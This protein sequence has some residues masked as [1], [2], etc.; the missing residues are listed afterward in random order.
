[1]AGI[2][3]PDKYFAHLHL[4]TEFSFLDGAGRIPDIVARAKEMGH[5]AVAITDHGTM[6]GCAE[7]YRECRKN[8][9]NPIIGCEFYVTPYGHSRTERKRYAVKELNG[10]PE[11]IRNYYHLNLWAKD[12]EGYRNLCRLQKMAN[13]EGFYMKPRIDFD[14]LRECHEGLI[15]GSACVLGEVADALSIGNKER[16]LER[17]RELQSIFDDDLY[18]EIMYHGVDIEAH[19]FPG[20]REVGKELSIP[21]IATN[22]AHYV[23]KED[24]GLQKALM[25][26]G[27]K[28]SLMDPGVNL[29]YDDIMG[30]G[31]SAPFAGYSD[32]SYRTALRN[33][34]M[35]LDDEEQI[36]SD[37]I[38]EMPAEL[39]MKDFDE[40]VH[41][42]GGGEEAIRECNNTRLVTEKCHLEMPW[43]KDIGY[44]VPKYDISTDWRYDE[45]SKDS[46][47]T[48]PAWIEEAVDK[49]F[50]EPD[51]K[52]NYSRP[53]DD[54]EKEDLRFLSWIACRALDKKVK[55]KAERGGK[56]LD[57][58]AWVKVDDDIAEYADKLIPDIH[59]IGNT[60]DEQFFAAHSFDEAMG[61]YRDRLAYEL[62]VVCRMHFLSYFEIVGDYVAWSRE[63]TF[64]GA[65]RGC[66]VPGT[67]VLTSNGI[68]PIEDV[69]ASDMVYDN[70]GTA[71]PLKTKFKY[72]VSEDMARVS[73]S[74]TDPIECTADHKVEV[75][76]ATV[77]EALVGKEAL[78]AAD[79]GAR[80]RS[81][82]EA[83]RREHTALRV[84]G[85]Y[86]PC[87]VLMGNG[88][89]IASDDGTAGTIGDSA[90]HMGISGSQ[91]VPN[92][93]D[94]GDTVAI[95]R[96]KIEAAL[97]REMR[98]AAAAEPAESTESAEYGEDANGGDG[99]C[100]EDSADGGNG[101]CDDG[102][103][104]GAIVYDA[105]GRFI[106][107]DGV[108]APADGIDPGNIVDTLASAAPVLSGIVRDAI[109]TIAGGDT[110]K[111]DGA[112][113]SPW[114]AFD[115]EGGSR[116]AGRS[117]SKQPRWSAS[118]Q[119]VKTRGMG[120]KN[121]LANRAGNGRRSADGRVLRR[122][123][124]PVPSWLRF[125]E[126][127]NQGNGAALR[128]SWVPAG[129]LP[130]GC[131]VIQHARNW[132]ACSSPLPVIGFDSTAEDLAESVGTISASVRGNLIEFHSDGDRVLSCAKDLDLATPMAS[133]LIGALAVSCE[134]AGDG[135]CIRMDAGLHRIASEV[136]DTRVHKQG[137]EHTQALLEHKLCMTM[138]TTLGL[139]GA[140]ISRVCASAVAVSGRCAAAILRGMAAGCSMSMKDGAASL[141][142]PGKAQAEVASLALARCL[143]PARH[144]EAANGAPIV[145]FPLTSRACSVLGLDRMEDPSLGVFD[146]PDGSI[147]VRVDSVEPFHY[148]GDVY[149]LSVNTPN[150]HSFALEAFHVSNSGAGSLLNYLLDITSVDPIPTDLMF[151]RFLNPN[152]LNMPDIDV[153]FP[154][155]FR[156]A[157]LKP[158][159]CERYGKDCCAEV[160]TYG[161]F[162]AKEAI[163]SSAR[164][165]LDHD[166]GIRVGNDMVSDRW[167]DD[168][169]RN[170]PKLKLDS[171]LDPEHEHYSPR[172]A[173][174]LESNPTWQRVWAFAKRIENRV[175]GKGKHASAYIAAP[176]SLVD[177]VPLEVAKDVR[178][179]HAKAIKEGKLPPDAPID[180]YMIQY[181]GHIVE[182][183]GYVKLDLLGLVDLDVLDMATKT[184]KKTYGMELDPLSFPQDDW[185]TFEMLHEGKYAGVF[186]LNSPGMGRVMDQLRPSNVD[187]LSAGIALFRPGPM[188]Y[189]PDF[190]KGKKDPSTVKYSDERL[191]GI[192]KSTYGVLCLDG[193]TMVTMGGGYEKRL[194]DIR[195]GDKVLSSDGKPHRVSK[196]M[197][198]GIRRCV[199]L[200]TDLGADVFCTPDH[201]WLTAD[202]YVETEK[203]KKGDLIQGFLPDEEHLVR[204][205]EP[206]SL[207]DWLLGLYLADGHSAI[208]ASPSYACESEK[209]AE[210]IKDFVQKEF[211]EMEGL[212]IYSR[213]HV[214]E[215]GNIGT[216]WYLSIGQKKRN[217]GGFSKNHIPNQFNEWLDSYGLYGKTRNEKIWPEESTIWT[218]LGFIE[219]DGC[220]AN[221]RINLANKGLIDGIHRTL[222]EYGIRSSTY[223]RD[224]HCWSLAFDLAPEL[225][226]IVKE[227]TKLTDISKI[228]D[229]YIPSSLLMR[230]E[231][232]VNMAETQKRSIKNGRTL[233]TDAKAMGFPLFDEPVIW[234]SVLS[235]EDAGD[236][237][238]YDITVDDK[239]NFVANG[240]ISHNCF[241]EEIM[242]MSRAIAGFTGGE[243]DELRKCLDEDTI[244][245][246]DRGAVPI[247]KV[248]GKGKKYSTDTDKI[249]T[250]DTKNFH[251]KKNVVQ[252]AFSNGKKQCVKLI[253]SDGSELVCTPDHKICVAGDHK[254]T[255]VQ[256]RHMYGKY[257]IQDLS[258]RYGDQ[259]VDRDKLFMDVMF[260]TD[261]Y[262]SSSDIHFTITDANRQYVDR[263]IEAHHSICNC[264]PLRKKVGTHDMLICSRLLRN[265]LDVTSSTASDKKMPEYFMHLD[266]ELQK[267]M[268]GLMIDLDGYVTRNT[269]RI[270]I[271]FNNASET[272]VRQMQLLL[273]ALGVQAKFYAKHSKNVDKDYYSVETAGT[274]NIR[275]IYQL[276]SPYSEKISG[277]DIE[278]VPDITNNN[279]TYRMP[280]SIWY[281]KV[282]DLVE[283]SGL[284]VLEVYN[285]N[286][287]R[288]SKDLTSTY[289]NVA[290]KLGLAGRDKLIER[291][292]EREVCFVK[293]VEI[294]NV[295]YRNV[296]DF[297]MTSGVQP[298]GFAGGILVHNCVAKKMLDKMP[299]MEPKFKD[300]ARASGTSEKTIEELWDAIM[301]AGSYSFNRCLSGDTTLL[302]VSPSGAVPVSIS[303]LYLSFASAD[304][305]KIP[306]L[307]LSATGEVTANMVTGVFFQGTRRTYEITL[308]NGRRVRATGNHRLMLADGTYR[309]VDNLSAGDALACLPDDLDTDAVA[310]ALATAPTAATEAIA[311]ASTDGAMSDAVSAAAANAAGTPAAFACPSASVSPIISIVPASTEPV[312]D[313]EIDSPEHNFFANGICSHNS[314]SLAYANVAYNGAFV[315]SH[316][317]DAFMSAMCTF[318]PKAKDEDLV[319][320]YLNEAKS[321]GVQIIQPHVNVSEADFS[322]PVP[323]V[324]CYG[325]A[326]IQ[327]VG[328][329]ADGIIAER[330]LNG[331]YKSFEDF[332]TRA[333]K[334]VTKQALEA[335]AHAGALDD[336]GWTRR[337]ILASIDAIAEERKRLNK[338]KMASSR[339]EGGL[340]DSLMGGGMLVHGED[341]VTDLPTGTIYEPQDAFDG[342][343][344]GDVDM[345]GLMAQD[346][347]PM[348]N[349]MSSSH[350]PAPS[351]SAAPAI[352]SG[353]LELV[354]PT[355]SEMSLEAIYISENAALGKHFS[356]TFEDLHEGQLILPEED[357]TGYMP[358]S[359]EACRK[360]GDH[361]KCLLIG[362]ITN[363][364]IWPT[365]KSGK[366]MCS[367]NLMTYG[368]SEQAENGYSP[369]KRDIR[370][371]VFPK[372]W[373]KLDVKP[374]LDDA[375][376]VWGTVNIEKPR[377]TEEA[378][379]MKDEEPRR[380]V[381]V[382][383]LEILDMAAGT[384][385]DRH[386]ASNVMSGVD[387]TSI[388]VKPYKHD[389]SPSDPESDRYTIPR[390]VVPTPAT[391]EAIINSKET[392]RRFGSPGGR[393]EV[394]IEGEE[395]DGPIIALKQTKGMVKWMSDKFGAR[396]V[397]AKLP[398]SISAAERIRNFENAREIQRLR[399]K[400]PK[401]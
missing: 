345:F 169:V 238:V 132:S 95:E 116:Q 216:T 208:G 170:H 144:S 147:A 299:W 318:K 342:F 96:A 161:Y 330:E 383:A 94:A 284:S 108:D 37:P 391:R 392:M 399:S 39:Y 99:A 307:C 303:H 136:L 2:I 217:N 259:R 358:M 62:G 350:T 120:G 98:E 324:I 188:A 282:M 55:P 12:Y 222:T 110:R 146:L 97:A 36:A 390:I 175:K 154:K 400:R 142:L 229:G 138:A 327:N 91:L 266:D 24:S 227:P 202:G 29:T 135:M 204:E 61:I 296:Y 221:R 31:T 15:C 82:V 104:V 189:I 289:A 194:K 199:K 157:E 378:E 280:D 374:R 178:A 114:E 385:N 34:Q 205:M 218:V 270:A 361:Q 201:K 232:M 264:N 337:A 192:L 7:F 223:Q 301:A 265:S 27:F 45:Y 207:R 394:V 75:I 365:K 156:N 111:I 70:T 85:S 351:D 89:A 10:H 184:I 233:F 16:S 118:M 56:P 316:W 66:F 190:I 90:A 336:M 274:Y 78:D 57:K 262:V 73:T 14:A 52:G 101:A 286:P 242:Q 139:G 386:G 79:S 92:D 42:L 398:S 234:A 241:Q 255:W 13:C 46:S 20:I 377:T 314:H 215:S 25:L 308:A 339:F 372:T 187:D 117:S 72:S 261:G 6:N 149:D 248:R 35:K 293:C 210:K 317:P 279:D 151:E 283:E 364:R 140:G 153:D 197:D 93:Y 19:A 381:F 228:R 251:I 155:V 347:N 206:F 119:Q 177:A 231:Y 195:I 276:L 158:Y 1:M 298:Q 171:L 244:F 59:H 281:Q 321:L 294:E 71:F 80:R 310:S 141:H 356:T 203:L 352:A 102:A 163:K 191:E 250:F 64:V 44:Q 168:A 245:W 325:L 22:D 185:A 292:L 396:A 211:P 355:D 47:F 5:D 115:G 322:V 388:P 122:N 258:R 48:V 134:G 18:L 129:K 291:F 332:C 67:R 23:M 17:A 357:D 81:Q 38:W 164:L 180:E 182:D 41:A 319:P 74:W 246:T 172:F 369:M 186:Q 401:E 306:V 271:G 304:R 77:L 137:F 160:V 107:I 128:T 252:S 237:H 54:D 83:L 382:D 331:P 68:K 389:G 302:T 86:E 254:L 113:I 50:A 323:G 335:L 395:T 260:L 51:E 105:P 220:Y 209:F 368:M 58:S 103:H 63:R 320:R 370:C 384:T 123:D 198:N 362:Q 343:G 159:L 333:P 150:R 60:P 363:L 173:A 375:V 334:E 371:M 9:L 269:S 243:S 367:F 273:N 379:R 174:E 32:E 305:H 213:T 200:H 181:D 87:S 148:E 346:A 349:P 143:I 11:H 257:A 230:E 359:A 360:M 84:P 329:A 366:M 376:E 152:R 214:C 30:T 326:G 33:A 278:K 288:K 49:A 236:H 196:V 290:E 311:T 277:I 26:M 275:R 313:I 76:D 167:L 353:T 226:P 8:D 3:T 109:G 295:G 183:L 249:S 165:L 145:S 125:P 328:K 112:S 28:K 341:G 354:P 393:V 69:D 193:D 340:F 179:A 21:V 235:V 65:G 121:G 263:F 312:F 224:A 239:H 373:E 338:E 212:R 268:I 247:K 88:G 315:K 53:M 387:V 100:G 297:T 285:R 124:R 126:T 162:K 344:R 240:K 219:G 225:M 127:G 166:E 253:F 130:A 267:Y 106:A 176:H 4:H 256:A 348:S 272:L 133:M 397:H 380:T 40:M 300:G 309:T 43:Q 287:P 131:Y